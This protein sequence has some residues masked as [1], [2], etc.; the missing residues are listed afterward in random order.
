[1]TETQYTD[2]LQRVE[3]L[4]KRKPQDTPGLPQELTR[5][6][7]AEFLGISLR[8]LATMLSNGDLVTRRVGPKKGKVMVDTISLCK[9]KEEQGF[10]REHIQVILKDVVYGGQTA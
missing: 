2:L 8:S 1:M 10:E 9:H 3:A 7:A 6:K 5:A 4:E